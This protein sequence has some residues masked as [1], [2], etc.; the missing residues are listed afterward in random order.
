MNREAR[1]TLAFVLAGFAAALVSTGIDYSFREDMS[2]NALIALILFSVA[3]IGYAGTY[4]AEMV[5]TNIEEGGGRFKVY[6]KALWIYIITWF[7]IYVI[8]YNEFIFLG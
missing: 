4:V 5:G 3:V 1:K 2:P 6:L 8:F 7:V